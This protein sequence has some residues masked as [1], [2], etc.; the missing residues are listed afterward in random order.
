MQ[1]CHGLISFYFARSC[2]KRLL[3]LRILDKFPGIWFAE[4]IPFDRCCGKKDLKPQPALEPPRNN[5]RG[6][7][8]LARISASAILESCPYRVN[9]SPKTFDKYFIS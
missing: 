4:Q 3:T 2:L 5:K 6:P 8:A 1:G 9:L 7:T